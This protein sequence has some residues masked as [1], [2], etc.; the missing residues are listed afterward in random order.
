M[1][2]SAPIDV[3]LAVRPAA[4]GIRQHVLQLLEYGDARRFSLSIAAPSEFLQSLPRDLPLADGIPLEIRARLAP[5]ADLRAAAR[6]AGLLRR[7]SPA[8]VHAHG[9]RAALIAALARRLHAFPLIVTAH[10]LIDSGAATR[11]GLAVIGSAADR[12]LAVSDPIAEGLR[13]HGVSGQKISVVPNGVDLARYAAPFPQARAAFGIPPDVFVVAAVARLSPEKGIDVL[14]EAALQAPELQFVIAG[15]GPQRAELEAKAPANVRLLGRVEDVRA[16]LFAANAVAVPSRL[17]GQGIVALEALAARRPVV[18]SRI[19]G[20]AAML[21]DSE[22]ALLVPSEDPAALAAALRRL[23]AEPELRTSL[24]SMGYNLVRERYDVRAQTA[25]VEQIY[26]KFAPSS[27]GKRED[28][29]RPPQGS[30]P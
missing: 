16:V 18:A 19:G 4:G 27:P 15:D 22:T 30:R 10:N 5:L 11:I 25:A 20:L 3:L 6:L 29:P 14:L 13:A 2:Q 12:I 21:S 1:S 26:T 17:E 24:A 28:A 23:A 8:I 9:L 7:R